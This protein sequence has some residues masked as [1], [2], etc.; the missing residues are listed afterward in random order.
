MPISC[1]SSA[2]QVRAQAAFDPTDD[3]NAP[4]RYEHHETKELQIICSMDELKQWL[5]NLGWDR[6]TVWCKMP[7][8]RLRLYLDRRS[9]DEVG[10]PY[11][12]HTFPE[13]T[14]FVSAI[15]WWR[16]RVSQANKGFA[17]FEGTFDASGPVDLTDPP[18][19]KIDAAGGT[20][21]ADDANEITRKKLRHNA[22]KGMGER[23]KG[24]G[25]SDE[26]QKKIEAAE[27]ALRE[28]KRVGQEYFLKHG[29][30]TNPDPKKCV[31][32]CRMGRHNEIQRLHG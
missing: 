6:L 28:K 15:K 18:T 11:S 31:V 32:A 22:R 5:P 8:C 9:Y 14:D 1:Q 26:L 12:I 25:M 19:A 23:W 21:E 29:W 16:K 7:I 3:W 20:S 27:V 17:V 13:G 4:L 24:K 2:T 10:Q 30:V